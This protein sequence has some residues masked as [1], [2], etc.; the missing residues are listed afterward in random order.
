MKDLI[1]ESFE[2]NPD[3]LAKLLATGDATLTHT[4]DKGKWGTEFPRLLMEVREELRSQQPTSVEGAEVAPEAGERMSIFEMRDQPLVYTTDQTNSLL[5]VQK[6]I[7]ANKQA[8]Y[9]LAGYAGTGK[10]TIAENI[11]RYAMANGRPVIVLAPTNK[12]VKVL[13]D[14]L[15]AS[16]VSTQASTI[17]RAV[18][19]EPDPI[20]GEWIPKANI[21]N[22]VVIVDESSM[23]SKEVMQDLLNATTR[24]NIVIFMGDSFQLE[25]VGE[26]SGLFTGKVQE[27]TDKSEL[28]EVRRQ[29]LDSSI[30]KIATLARTDNRAYVPSVS[31]ENFKVASGRQE[32]INDFKAAIKNNENVAM[33]VATNKERMLMNNIARNEKFGP[34]KSILE[35]GE[36]IISVANSIDFPNSE[37]FKINTLRDME[38]H[39]LTFD[40]KD[41]TVSYDMYLTYFKDE[42]N[43]IQ[44]LMHFPEL[45]RPSLYHAQILKAI[46]Q[47]APNLLEG[48]EGMGY[49]IATKKGY[50]LSPAVVIGTYGYSI[51]AHK[52]QGSQWEKVFVNQDFVGSGWNGARWYYTAITRSSQDVEV[53]PTVNNTKISVDEINKKIN[54]LS[55]NEPVVVKTKPLFTIEKARQQKTFRNKPLE[56]V[57]KIPSQKETVVAM[58]NRDG[59]IFINEAGMR[60]KFEQKAWTKPAKQL[61]GSSATPLAEDQFKS[62]EEWFTFALIHE[63]KHDSIKKLEGE[64]TGAYEDRINEAAIQDLEKNYKQA[65]EKEDPFTC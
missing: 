30:L 64:T 52:S 56:F 2:Q 20:T 6:M 47:S 26:D 60:Q 33:I 37:V 7:D 17:H 49:I 53:L 59:K 27:V 39:R 22:A 10:T 32:F 38:K 5:D 44:L 19:G 58:Q 3:A 29:S 18:Y 31:I 50:K 61:D 34:D 8:Y 46:R 12:A 13:N 35:E 51:T 54:Q 41:K 43:K 4:Q 48:L 55:E 21:K 11:A 25:P 24:N 14:K 45:D 62:F 15:R 42:N 16:N 28:K 23:I 9:L 40:F 57:E 1:K 36:T 65:P 63:V